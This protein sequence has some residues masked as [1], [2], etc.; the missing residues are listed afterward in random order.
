M[1]SQRFS[2][3]TQDLKSGRISMSVPHIESS[4]DSKGL[5]P[6]NAD[7]TDSLPPSHPKMPI[8]RRTVPDM[9]LMGFLAQN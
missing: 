7:N 3:D 9:Y 8:L 1:L 6:V 2:S 4:F 5:K